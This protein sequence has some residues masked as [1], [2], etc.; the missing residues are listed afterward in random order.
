[1][2]RSDWLPPVCYRIGGLTGFHRRRV[3]PPPVRT[4]E[5]FSLGVEPGQLFGAGK[6]SEMVTSFAVLGLVINDFID[7]FH[8]SGG[9]IPLE[10][11]RIVISVP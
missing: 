10:V 3:I 9:K 1:M 4:Q 5:G 6:V 2:V 11:G 8:L 7:Q